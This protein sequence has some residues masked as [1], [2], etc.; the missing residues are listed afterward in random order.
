MSKD[1]IQNGY[2]KGLLKEHGLKKNPTDVSI[3]LTGAN[4]ET[5]IGEAIKNKFTSIS[6]HSIVTEFPEN[7]IDSEFNFEDFNVLIMCHGYTYMDW[8]ENV[9]DNETE[10]IINVNLYGS[11]RLIKQFVNDTIDAPHRKKIISIGSMAYRQVLNGSAAYCA[12]KAGLNMFIRCAAWELAPKGFDVYIIHPSNVYDTPMSNDT[13]EHLQRYRNLD[14]N[15]AMSYWS[16][17]FI[18]KEPLTKE[19]IAQH[20]EYIV[21]NDVDYLSGS[22]IELGGGQ[23]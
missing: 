15:E 8:L 20:V 12:S 9:P 14:R 6:G 1:K 19:E 5:S 10:K 11:I 21:Y 13:I 3:A 17:N 22:P 4:R 23:R 18:R 2:I 7:V 16:A